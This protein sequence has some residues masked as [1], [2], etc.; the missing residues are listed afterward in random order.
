MIATQFTVAFTNPVSVRELYEILARYYGQEL[1]EVGEGILVNGLP[2]D[3][4]V[5]HKNDR[6]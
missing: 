6:T 3:W 1:V 2:M 5:V 4:I